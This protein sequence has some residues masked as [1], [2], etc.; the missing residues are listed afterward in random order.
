MKQ[1]SNTEHTQSN[2]SSKRP[3]WTSG[4]CFAV[5]M[6][7]IVSF[8]AYKLANFPYY[9]ATLDFQPVETKET[10]HGIQFLGD[11]VA[12][13]ER[14][15]VVVDFVIKSFSAMPTTRPY[16]VFIVVVFSIPVAMWMLVF[17]VRGEIRRTVY[18]QRLTACVYFIC[19]VLPLATFYLIRLWPGPYIEDFYTKEYARLTERAEPIIDAL[20]VYHKEHGKYPDR[21]ME[22]VPEYLAEVPLAGIRVCPE[23]VYVS[24]GREVGDSGQPYRRM[25]TPKPK[26]ASYDLSVSLHKVRNH[27]ASD[28]FYYLYYQPE[29]G[30]PSSHTRV[31]QWAIVSSGWVRLP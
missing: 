2:T 27:Y 11:S 26:V 25:N 24:N 16:I 29:R 3:V 4:F 22:L 8:G 17:F 14:L 30:Y 5:F 31:N 6:V 13:R 21:L 23:F 10:D 9:A 1:D 20:G 28:M 18:K 19:A 12:S 7:L 15:G